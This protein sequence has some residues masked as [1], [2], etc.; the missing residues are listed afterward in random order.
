SDI[1]CMKDIEARYPEMWADW[2]RKLKA[3]GDANG[4]SP[5]WASKGLWRIRETNEED[6]D[7]D[8]HF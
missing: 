5:E 4:K 3:W 8:G 6:R 2:E 7:I 1:A